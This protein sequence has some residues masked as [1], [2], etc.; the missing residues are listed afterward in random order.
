MRH[1]YAAFDSSIS[2][3]KALFAFPSSSALR[4][5]CR[6][7]FKSPAISATTGRGGV[8][9]GDVAFGAGVVVKN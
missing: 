2:I 3:S 1:N 6:P 9:Q 4:A 5:I 7:S 8:Q